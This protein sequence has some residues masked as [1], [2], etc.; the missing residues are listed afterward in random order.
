MYIVSCFEFFIN[1]VS[2]IM[3]V[4]HEMECLIG[5]K[6]LFMSDQVIHGWVALRPVQHV[7]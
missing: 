3:E 5:V 7:L 6:T 1:N 4:I 2:I